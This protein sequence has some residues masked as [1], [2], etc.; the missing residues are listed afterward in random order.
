[1]N[2]WMMLAIGSALRGSVVIALAWLLTLMLRR[3]CFFAMNLDYPNGSGSSRQS[4]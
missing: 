1:M 4:Y 3:V 2:D